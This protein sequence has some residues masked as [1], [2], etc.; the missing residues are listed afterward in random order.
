MEIPSTSG[1]LHSD[2]VRLLSLQ[3]HRKTDRFFAA[4]GVQSEQSTSGGFFHFR[5]AAFSAGLK[6]KVGLALA[7]RS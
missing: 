4:S 7:N 3:A 1:R 2:F 5:R 6:S